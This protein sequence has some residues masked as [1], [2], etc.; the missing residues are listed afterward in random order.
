MFDLMDA[1]LRALGNKNTQWKKVLYF[2]VK[3][4]RQ[5]LS[6]YYTE[7]PAT[8]GLLLI[9][10]HILDPCWKLRL[11]KKWGKGMDLNPDDDGSYTMQ[12]QEEFLHY[13]ENKYS[14]KHP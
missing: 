3:S 7:V 6:K 8:T 4:A 14:D 9:S 1:V 13:V 5:K 11:F 12:Y 2:A 10:A